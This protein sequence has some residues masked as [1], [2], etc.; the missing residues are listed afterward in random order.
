MQKEP[1]FFLPSLTFR[2]FGELG[3]RNR[4]LED[5]TEF[6]FTEFYIEGVGK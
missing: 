2:F 5:F 6:F 1:S 3:L 4:R